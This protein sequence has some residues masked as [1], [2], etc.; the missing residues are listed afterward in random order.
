M[1]IYKGATALNLVNGFSLLLSARRDFYEKDKHN[2]YIIGSCDLCF[3]IIEWLKP[4]SSQTM[5][6]GAVA[7]SVT[8]LICVS[9]AV[10][11]Y[12]NIISY[13][14]CIFGV[15]PS[16]LSAGVFFIWMIMGLGA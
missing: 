3:L 13:I 6:L 12:R 14:T 2:L 8:E 9:Y 10:K 11:N 1:I 5:V 15:I 4:V 16:V 7:L